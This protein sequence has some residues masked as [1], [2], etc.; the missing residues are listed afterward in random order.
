[1]KKHLLLAACLLALAG[2][3]SEYIIST[4]DGQ[5]ILDQ[6]GMPCLLVAVIPRDEVVFTDGWFVQGL[7]GTGSY[8]YNVTELFVPGRR[9]FELFT[10][11]PNRGSS[12]AFRMGLIPITAAGHAAWALGVA[13]SMLDDVTELAATKVRMGDD[14]SIA[15]RASFQRNLSHHSAAWKALFDDFLAGQGGEQREFDISTDYVQYVDGRR[16]YDGVDTFL[17]SR[18]I[19]LSYGEP[20]DSPDAVTV[21][22]LGNRKNEYFKQ[23]LNRLGVEA[24]EDAVALIK[25]MRDTGQRTAVVSASENCTAI[26]RV[27]GLLD[28]FEVRV[29]G[30][31]AARWG[32]PGKPAPDT[33][34]KAAEMLDTPPAQAVV[35]EDAVSGVQAGHAGNFGLVVGVERLGRGDLLARNGADVVVTDLRTLLPAD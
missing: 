18:G 26:L 31:E 35:F 12:P 30:E 25:V 34:L 15:H 20:S 23:E 21:C 14:A 17:R 4:A 33:F 8:D 9:T 32:L 6:G 1:M 10:R 29:T 3:S 7:K 22:G 27:A 13:K 28:L 16:R 5:M 24:F 19:V 11:L 2:C